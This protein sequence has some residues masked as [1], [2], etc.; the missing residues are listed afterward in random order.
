M[1]NVNLASYGVEELNEVQMREV[2]G[3]GFGAFIAI[4]S[5]CIYLYN[6]A[7]DFAEGFRE[8]FG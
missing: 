7:D 5:A 2:N 8:G 3:G 1:R 4:A 6:N